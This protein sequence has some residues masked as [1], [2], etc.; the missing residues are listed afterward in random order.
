MLS[1][2]GGQLK[3]V[4]ELPDLPSKCQTLEFSPDGKSL[5]YGSVSHTIHVW[6]V[7]NGKATLSTVLTDHHSYISD[8]KF[9]PSGKFMLSSAA[10]D[11]RVWDVSRGFQL[12][13]VYYAPVNCA[14]FVN[15]NVILAGEATG[16]LL[17]LKFLQQ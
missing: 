14:A 4:Q 7:T 17:Q 3:E 10:F 12:V 6:S 13:S 5:V 16:N 15:D 8:I 11:L 2:S 1:F 9:S